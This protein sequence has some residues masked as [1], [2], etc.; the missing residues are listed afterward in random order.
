MR[1]Q[2][3]WE[4]CDSALAAPLILD[5]ARLSALALEREEFGTQSQLAFFFKDPAGTTEQSLHRQYELLERWVCQ[6]VRA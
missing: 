4:G 1:L 6:E 5:L 2:F 3:T